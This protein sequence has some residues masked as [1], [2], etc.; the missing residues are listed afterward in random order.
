[1]PNVAA[2]IELFHERIIFDLSFVR[3]PSDVVDGL[4]K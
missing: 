1:M 2:V 4:T 3:S